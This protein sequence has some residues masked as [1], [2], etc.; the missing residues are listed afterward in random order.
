[1][2]NLI[3]NYA[4]DSEVIESP[5]ST[6]N[7]HQASSETKEQAINDEATDFS[8]YPEKVRKYMIT[9]A[10]QKTVLYQGILSAFKRLSLQ[11]KDEVIERIERLKRCS[12][13]VLE[14][15][16]DN[17][18]KHSADL[19]GLTHLCPVC[20]GLYQAEKEKKVDELIA[21]M[22]LEGKRVLYFT[23]NF[24]STVT[25]KINR[26]VQIYHQLVRYLH[27]TYLPESDPWHEY[28][29]QNYSQHFGK[30]SEIAYKVNVKQSNA[31]QFD[32]SLDLFLVTEGEEI[33]PIQ[34]TVDVYL[35]LLM[36]KKEI[37]NNP[38]S[39][40]SDELSWDEAEV[41]IRQNLLKINRDVS[42]STKEKFFFK[43]K[44]L[45]GLDKWFVSFGRLMTNADNFEGGVILPNKGIQVIHTIRPERKYDSS[46]DGKLFRRPSLSVLKE[47]FV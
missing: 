38:I 1:M 27:Y 37:D 4:C 34:E 17:K 14:Y 15:S 36:N 26:T 46:K 8:W 12:E 13:R 23:F 7:I 33:N 22:S 16:Q 43:A 47:F 24:R 21:Q 40:L 3:E 39:S 44:N 20:K 2:D 10:L 29:E 9:G 25:S 31:I 18:R 45:I 42:V 35:P 11:D 32:A 6:D 19:C 5:S 30:V 28:N 41:L